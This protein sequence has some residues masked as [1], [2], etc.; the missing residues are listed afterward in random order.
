MWQEIHS[1]E[2]SKTKSQRK[3]WICNFECP[4][5]GAGTKC[6]RKCQLRI[7]PCIPMRP[8]VLPS[9]SQKYLS[10]QNFDASTY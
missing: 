10:F 1:G 7:L 6:G 5:D 3:G 8:H 4:L 9:I 2:K